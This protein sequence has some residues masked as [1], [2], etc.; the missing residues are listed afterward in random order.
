MA[1]V[2]QM[3]ARAYMVQCTPRSRPNFGSDRKVMGVFTRS[4]DFGEIMVQRMHARQAQA[5]RCCQDAGLHFRERR[6]NAGIT[7][8]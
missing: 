1:I 6:Q 8:A 7:R 3:V 4:N 5:S 2:N